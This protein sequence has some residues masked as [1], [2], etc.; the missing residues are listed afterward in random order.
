MAKIVHIIHIR[1]YGTENVINLKNLNL[2][3]RN[4]GKIYTQHGEYR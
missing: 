4:D 1:F 2:Y 3:R